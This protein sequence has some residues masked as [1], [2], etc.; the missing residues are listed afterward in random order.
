MIE[1]IYSEDTEILKMPSSH[2]NEKDTMEYIYVLYK[3]SVSNT[4]V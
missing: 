1:F 4:L 3:S 2:I